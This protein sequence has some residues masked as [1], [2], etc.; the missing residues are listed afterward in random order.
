MKRR[1]E[2]L[3]AIAAAI[4]FVRLLDV[5]WYT[6]PAFHPSAF[7]IHWMDIAAPIGIGG[8]W[9][10]FFI[11]QLRPVALIPLGDPSVKETLERGRH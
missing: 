7:S 6:V 2:T 1:V 5:F 8:L 11:W 10:A 9:L 4:F 3:C